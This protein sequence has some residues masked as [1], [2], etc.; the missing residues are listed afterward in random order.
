ML[1]C[2]LVGLPNVGKSTLFNALGRAAAEVSSYPFCTIDSNV[3]VT[4]V[5]DDRL[6]RLAEIFEQGQAFPTTIQF[7]DIAGLVR[8]ASKGQGLGN[9]FLGHIREVDCIVHLVRCFDNP[10][11]AH[12]DGLVDPVRDIE[13]VNL[14]LMLAD[15]E[16][17]ENR[18]RRLKVAK[19]RP[20]AEVSRERETLEA[21]RER[22]Q[23]GQ[24]ARTMPLH[25]DEAA[26]VRQLHLLT[27][28]PV[29][30]VANV[31]ETDIA[32]PGPYLS[33]ARKWADRCGETL[34]EVAAL[35]EADLA[36]LTPAEA[37]LFAEELGLQE[38]SLT[39]V[40]QTVYKLLN[41]ITFFTGVGKEVRA[42]TVRDGTPAPE[43]AG[44]IHSDMQRGF[45]RAEVISFER[46]SEVG[47]WDNARELGLIRSEGKQYIVRDGDVI[48]FK[49]S[50]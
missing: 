29:L 17:V 21:L 40:V 23:E 50:H 27:D 9:R 43:A 44:K 26:M 46:L 14:E 30:Y 49:F 28:K 25:E 41:L 16:T 5:Q 34:I 42:W 6:Q 18:L 12:V 1:A 31:D 48:Q 7:V 47:S 20:R 24:P 19:N 32:S 8:G 22:L 4:P 2:G 38:S 45:I 15:L 36:Q 3:C 11:V 33:A 10:E 37:K 35:L 13:T 39:R